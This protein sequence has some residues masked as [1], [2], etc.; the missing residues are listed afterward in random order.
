MDSTLAQMDYQGSFAIISEVIHLYFP[1]QNTIIVFYHHVHELELFRL[2]RSKYPTTHQQTSIIINNV[3]HETNQKIL[4]ILTMKMYEI[5]VKLLLHF[6]TLFH[7]S[8]ILDS[9][10]K[11]PKYINDMHKTLIQLVVPV[12]YTERLPQKNTMKKKE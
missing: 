10:A 6:L 7:R 1:S 2:S 5:C 8:L 9:K 12:P 4:T 3:T 11:E